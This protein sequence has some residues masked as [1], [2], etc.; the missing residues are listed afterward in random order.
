MPSTSRD[1]HFNECLFANGAGTPTQMVSV[2][3]S[4]ISIKQ[5]HFQNPAESVL[6]FVD[7]SGAICTISDCTTDG[8]VPLV[9][10]TGGIP[11][12]WRIGD[13]AYN[14]MTSNS[15]SATIGAGSSNVIVTHGLS[16]IPRMEDITLT[17][18]GLPNNG[19]V[20]VIPSAIDA[21]TFRIYGA[22]STGSTQATTLA[23]N[24]AWNIRRSR[25]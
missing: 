11:V 3:G 24:V 12:T 5:C 14:Y 25:G 22:N 17:I 7:G 21:T 6:T 8:L 18:S 10:D 13:N 1:W 2:S 23:L 16:Y 19:I 20:G 15:G 9:P 4:Q